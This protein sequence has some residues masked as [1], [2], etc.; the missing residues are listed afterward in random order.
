MTEAISDTGPLLHLR[1]IGRLDALGVF[2]RLL[3]PGSVADE[4]HT[5]GL[6]L[7]EAVP[8]VS[9]ALVPVSEEQRNQA[10]AENNGAPVHPADAEVFVLA[11]EDGFLRTVLTD[12]LALRRLLEAYGA[13]VTGSVGVLVRAFKLGRLNRH[14]LDSAIDALF[15]AST[16]H[17]S[18]AFR[19]YVRQMLADLP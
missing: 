2:D 15:D 4:L 16:L 3:V 18:Q 14:D 19:A 17:L 1:E 8:G 12:D 13:T 7:D 9:V 5:Y 11:R 10:L 6:K